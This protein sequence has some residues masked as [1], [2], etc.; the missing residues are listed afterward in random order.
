MKNKYVNRSKIS[1]AKFRELARLFSLDLTASQI[2]ELTGLNRNTVNRYVRGIRERISEYCDVTAPPGLTQPDEGK[3]SSDTARIVGLA[4]RNERVFA[5][6]VTEHQITQVAQKPPN[7]SSRSF[8]PNLSD[9]P[10][11][12]AIAIDS[13]HRFYL[14]SEA[15]Y[16]DQ[17]RRFKR[18]EGFW[19]YAQTRLEK[20]KGMRQ[21]TFQLHLK[22]CQFRFNLPKDSIYQTVLTIVRKNP[23]F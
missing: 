8:H 2:A 10:F 21:S 11:Q 3:K 16:R 18:L 5:E 7:S 15:E 19:G 6:R 17:M 14:C 12:M 20:F 4:E 23:L 1:E 13:E 22:E 9:L